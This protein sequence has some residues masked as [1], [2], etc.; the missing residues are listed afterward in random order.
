MESKLKPKVTLNDVKQQIDLYVEC[1]KSQG[2]KF[3]KFP[4]EVRFRNL[5]QENLTPCEQ[6]YL[7]IT[8]FAIHELD[9]E[10]F[11][12][13]PIL[14][15]DTQ[16]FQQVNHDH[17]FYWAFAS[18]VYDFFKNE[19]SDVFDDEISNRYRLLMDVLMFYSHNPNPD[20]CKQ[21]IKQALT[22]LA[23]RIN[24]VMIQSFI[25]AA[26]I[27]YPLLEGIARRIASGFVTKDGISL[28]DISFTSPDGEEIE[29][30]RDRR[31]NRL[32]ELLRLVEA[33]TD[34]GSLRNDLR[35]Y[36]VHFDNVYSNYFGSKKAYD[37]IDE[38][39]NELLHGQQHWQV[40]YGA[41]V[42]LI[43][44]L[45]NSK[46]SAAHYDSN[47]QSLINREFSSYSPSWQH[48]YYPPV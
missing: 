20:L 46:I 9:Y 24:N 42:N 7:L 34:D 36:R 27:S 35:E 41:I 45:L 47:Y 4:E 23:P 11:R 39:R 22:S 28:Q 17:F 13:L 5:F 1:W 3:I 48:N 40:M 21:R 18:D 2:D 38:Q 15:L 14:L 8:K 32:N 44:L 12:K 10:A 31:V 19:I 16:R 33:K 37:I 26:H 30:K 43:C 25:V 6:K 29:I